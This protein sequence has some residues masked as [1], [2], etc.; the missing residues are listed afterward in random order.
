MTDSDYVTVRLG[1]AGGDDQ[2]L[3][4]A[5]GV[6]RDELLALDVDAVEPLTGEAA[7]G[8]KGAGV[9]LGALLVRLGGAVPLRAVV[10]ALLRWARGSG[11]TVEVTLDGDT[12]RLGNASAEQQE[13]IIDAWLA[14][15]A[16]GT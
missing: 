5:A 11:R 7:P 16:G 9:V 12:L 4:D 1:V 8:A 13:R 6:L 10:D 15:H 3:A 2:E 14:R